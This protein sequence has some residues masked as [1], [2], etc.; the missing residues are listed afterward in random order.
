MTSP[1]KFKS[2]VAINSALFKQDRCFQRERCLFSVSPSQPGEMQSYHIGNGEF[3][4]REK[5]NFRSTK[6]KSTEKR[7]KSILKQVNLGNLQVMWNLD[8]Q[9][10]TI[11]NIKNQSIEMHNILKRQPIEVTRNSY[12]TLTCQLLTTIHGCVLFFYK[13]N[14]SLL[15]KY[16]IC[17]FLTKRISQSK[18]YTRPALLGDPCLRIKE[19][20]FL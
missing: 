18:P 11:R 20:R 2:R 8:F 7:T 5:I 9:K 14:P 3:L 15:K 12:I 16:K 1:A 10:N 4:F 17:K 19:L 13:K 6:K